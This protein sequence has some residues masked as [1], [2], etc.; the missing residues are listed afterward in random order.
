MEA[1]DLK[2][3]VEYATCQGELIV[4][5]APV[6]GRWLMVND[7][8]FVE[9]TD[10]WGPCAPE[11]RRK[12][13]G[14]L[15]GVKVETYET[16]RDG[17]R[18]ASTKKVTVRPSRDVKGL[19]SEYLVLHGEALRKKVDERDEQRRYDAFMKVQRERIAELVKTLPGDATART[20]ATWE[21]PR[22]G[23]RTRVFEVNLNV[24][25]KSEEELVAAVEEL[26]RTFQRR[27]KKAL[28]Q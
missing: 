10:P 19:W 23:S 17:K 9:D 15:K 2:A 27:A 28:T 1:K 25:C 13:R 21:Y 18:V 12:R 7:G 3:G 16:N 11:A 14:T 20:Y 24:R 4:P 26:R 6:H 5:V 22:H 8:E